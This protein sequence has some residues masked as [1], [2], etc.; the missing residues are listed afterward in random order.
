M[1][2]V[3]INLQ[4][5]EKILVFYIHNEINILFPPD[6]NIINASKYHKSLG[7]ILPVDHNF[8]PPIFHKITINY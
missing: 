6:K 8:S 1:Q 7:F 2:A 5:N 4:W 3:G